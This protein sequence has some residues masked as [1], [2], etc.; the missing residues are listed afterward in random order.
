[1][2]GFFLLVLLSIVTALIAIGVSKPS[3]RRYTGGNSHSTYYSGDYN[4][5]H[6]CDSF[7]GDFGGGD[8]GGC[9]GG[10]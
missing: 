2:S 1:M 5:S 7:G 4:N 10:D 6:N 8:G 3:N 9:G